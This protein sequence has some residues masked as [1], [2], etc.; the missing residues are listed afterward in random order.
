MKT[1]IG[2]IEQSFPFSQFYA[3]NSWNFNYRANDVSNDTI[4]FVP[5]FFRFCC[6]TVTK[7]NFCTTSGRRSNVNSNAP[8]FGNREKIS[9]GH[10]YLVWSRGTSNHCYCSSHNIKSCHPCTGINANTVYFVVPLSWGMDTSDGL[11]AI[12]E[13]SLL[14][15]WYNNNGRL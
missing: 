7:L 5:I 12:W 15:Q 9:H 3:N 11:W 10:T 8:A 4:N 14:L 1:S 2:L 13:S 6:F